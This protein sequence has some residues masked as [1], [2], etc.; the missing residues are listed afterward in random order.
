MVYLLPITIAIDKNRD[1]K[2]KVLAYYQVKP[3]IAS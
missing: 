2:N 1:F 3:I